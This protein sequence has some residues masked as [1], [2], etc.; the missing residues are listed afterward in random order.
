[1]STLYPGISQLTFSDFCQDANLIDKKFNLSSADRLFIAANYMDSKVDQGNN[2]VNDL[3][4]FE[5]LEIIVRIVK[6][7]YVETGTFSTLYEGLVHLFNE[8]LSQYNLVHWQ[9]WRD[10]E[11][12][13]LEVNDL[14]EF[15]LD[16]L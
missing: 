12:W 8:V 11:L 5:F 1:M 16:H 13:T 2:S 6:A 3:I 15:N 10:E 7:K 14:F 9:K 4:R